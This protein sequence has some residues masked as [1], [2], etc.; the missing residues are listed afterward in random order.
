MMRQVT[1]GSAPAPSPS[2]SRC[3]PSGLAAPAESLMSVSVSSAGSTDPSVPSNARSAAAR[4]LSRHLVISPQLLQQRLRRRPQLI[5]GAAQVHG[6]ARLEHVAQLD[7]DDARLVTT[8]LRQRHRGARTARTV[9]A[10]RWAITNV[11]IPHPQ[12]VRELICSC[13]HHL[14]AVTTVRVARR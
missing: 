7:E 1:A 11:R 14:A 4:P 8:Q 9:R 13:L 2:T 10:R 3:T 12:A 6:E 5:A